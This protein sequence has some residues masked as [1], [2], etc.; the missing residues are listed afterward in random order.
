MTFDWIWI[1]VDLFMLIFFIKLLLD[2]LTIKDDIDK[3]KKL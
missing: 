3:N 1:T 2:I